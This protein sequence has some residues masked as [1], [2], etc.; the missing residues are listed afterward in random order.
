MDGNNPALPDVCHCTW[1]PVQ[2]KRF[3]TTCRGK[4]ICLKMNPSKREE[5]ERHAQCD[6]TRCAVSPA[7]LLQRSIFGGTGSAFKAIRQA[8]AALMVLQGLR[9]DK[10]K[11]GSSHSRVR[12]H[13]VKISWSTTQLSA[14][15]KRFL[16]VNGGK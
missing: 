14:G 11:T 2:Q 10:D 15:E 13:S 3:E 6:G 1:H 5:Q 8:S 4:T 9:K 7:V 12:S 16:E